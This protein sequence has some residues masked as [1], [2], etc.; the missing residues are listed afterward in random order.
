MAII[1]SHKLRRTQII[2]G[3]RIKKLIPLCWYTNR[4]NLGN[5]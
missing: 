5:L 1:R 4:N 3:L 2:N